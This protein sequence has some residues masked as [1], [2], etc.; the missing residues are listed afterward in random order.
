LS[1]DRLKESPQPAGLT[2]QLRPYQA[3]GL[4]WMLERETRYPRIRQID[5]RYQSF[6]VEK[7]VYVNKNARTITLKRPQC[8][9]FP[10]GGILAGNYLDLSY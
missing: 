2:L 6:E 10:L 7:T 4:S 9:E 5:I 1:A 8:P 3:Q